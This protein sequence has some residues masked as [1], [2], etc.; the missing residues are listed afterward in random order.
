V[1]QASVEELAKAPGMNK[2]AAEAVASFFAQQEPDGGGDEAI[3][4]EIAEAIEEPT[5]G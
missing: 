3:S 5:S 1:R 2:K 4:Q